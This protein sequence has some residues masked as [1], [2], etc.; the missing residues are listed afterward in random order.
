M[1]DNEAVRHRY[2]EAKFSFIVTELDVALTFYDIAQS[3][4][5]DAKAERNL[6]NAK[7]AYEMAKRFLKDA[8]LTWNMRSDI[9]ERL[10]KLAPM[11]EKSKAGQAGP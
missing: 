1:K 2:D 8:I 6:E 4:R 5:D 3:T 7:E 10:I 11:I 9:E